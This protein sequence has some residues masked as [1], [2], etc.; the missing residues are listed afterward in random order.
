MSLRIE[1]VFRGLCA[2]FKFDGR[3]IRKKVIYIAN[4]YFALLLVLI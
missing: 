4:L 3:N 2:V 1:S